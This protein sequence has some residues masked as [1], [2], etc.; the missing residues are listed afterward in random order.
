M[1]NDIEEYIKFYNHERLQKRLSGLSPL[2]YR[3]KVLSKFYLFPLSTW[4]GAV[5]NYRAF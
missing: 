2:E 1:K 5:H 3:A 4:Q